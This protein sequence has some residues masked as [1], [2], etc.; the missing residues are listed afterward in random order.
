MA[1]REHRKTS[2]RRVSFCVVTVSDSRTAKTD[3]SGELIEKLASGQG[4]RIV[5]RS[6]VR[7]EKTEILSALEASF[8]S[9][10]EAVVFTGGT[11]ITSRDI[12]CETL[13]PLMSKTLDGF[14]EIFR[15]LSYGQV[16]S[17]AMMSGAMAGVISGRIVFCLPGS[18]DAVRLAME[19]IILP[20]VGHIVREMG[21]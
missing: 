8:S 19:S 21:R 3:S 17:A 15:Y 18:P 7:D 20:E 9:G 13:R 4:H 10:G 1:S 14:G 6:V 12:T 11:G 5:M 16:G 2:P